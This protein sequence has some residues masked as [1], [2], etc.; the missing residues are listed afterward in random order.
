[1]RQPTSVATPLTKSTARF[2]FAAL[3]ITPIGCEDSPATPETGASEPSPNASILPSPLASTRPLPLV[4]AGPNTVSSLSD[5]GSADAEPR[6]P[7]SFESDVLLEPDT[8]LMRETA[9][10]VL[11]AHF[12]WEPRTAGGRGPARGRFPARIEL[13]SLGRL[14]FVLESDRMALPEGSELR[15]R[16]DR[17]GHL[18]LWPKLA[19]YRVLSPGTLRV[20]FEELR[21]DVSPLQD[22]KTERKEGGKVLGL[23]VQVDTI[24]TAMG[25]LVLEQAQVGALGGSSALLC[26][27]LSELVLAKPDNRACKADWLPLKA[28][29]GWADGG[30]FGFLVTSLERTQD[31]KSQH[32]LTPPADV[33]YRQRLLPDGP[34]PLWVTDEELSRLEPGAKSK[35]NSPTGSDRQPPEQGLVL[36]NKFTTPRYF[37]LGGELLG[38]LAPN[39][40]V[41][42]K[43]LR[44]G[45]Y[46]L[47][48][49]DFL[50][51]D[52]EQRHQV[53]VPGRKTLGMPK[54][55]DGKP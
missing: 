35:P 55:P 34:P 54:K 29:Y 21:A 33:P 17:Y 20:L 51:L 14:R 43:T 30:R 31:L 23:P 52:E 47:T 5:A 38:W 48:A 25:T 15:A 18:L 37:T 28:E 10:A 13:S 7:I 3:L 6:P 41:H 9:G 4:D 12:A 44:P 42:L 45:G 50:G 22:A 19:G 26:R 46:T 11:E 27:L 53:N 24:Q 32:F 36:T 16:T 1:M 8:A 2:A 39:G 40:Q 49:R